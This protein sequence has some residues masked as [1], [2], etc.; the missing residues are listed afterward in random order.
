[1]G[2]PV[3]YPQIPLS[4]SMSRLVDCEGGNMITDALGDVEKEMRNR[5]MAKMREHE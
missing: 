4:A 3:S 1:M 2:R 5:K